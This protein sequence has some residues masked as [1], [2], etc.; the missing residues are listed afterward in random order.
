MTSVETST[1]VD[2][3]AT[4]ATG[5]AA[6]HHSDCDIAAD[7]NKM[8]DVEVVKHGSKSHSQRHPNFMETYVCSNSMAIRCF[9]TDSPCLKIIF[10]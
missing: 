2:K 8:D 7:A 5:A 3:D 6:R 10:K 1:A 9:E 4:E